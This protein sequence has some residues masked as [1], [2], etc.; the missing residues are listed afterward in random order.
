MDSPDLSVIFPAYNEETRI[1]PSLEKTL[2]YLKNKGGTFE[3]IIVDD[4]SA[5]RT[6]EL[7]GNIVERNPEVHLLSLRPNRG[8]GNAVKEG[9]MTARGR[10]IFFTDAD[11]STPIGE[12]ENFLTELKNH[13]IVIGSRSI[14]GAR[15][16]VHEPLYRE[17][18]GKLFNKFVRALAVPGFVDTQ[19]GAKMFRRDAAK[20]IFPYLKTARF[21][22]DVEVLY[23][24]R[25]FGLSVKE[26]PVEWHYSANT[27]VRTFQDGPRMLWDLLKI[28]WMHRKTK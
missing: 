23:L 15:V 7:A 9:V 4:G 20:K 17:L 11:L 28:R 19:C 14:E 6:A 12:I 27:R 3:I 8:K 25:R 24:A 22:F 21:S 2:A 1:V 26:M 10:S 16:V 13:D 18:L 5:D